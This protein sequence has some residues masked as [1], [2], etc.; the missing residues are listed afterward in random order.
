MKRLLL[1]CVLFFAASAVVAAGCNQQSARAIAHAYVLASPLGDGNELANYVRAN[2]ALFTHGGAAIRCAS[3]LGPR[4]VRGGINAY[5]PKAYERAMG[6][7][8]SQFAPQVADSINSGAVDLYMMGAEL[9][10]LAQVLP[11][12]AN[13]NYQPFLTTG[14]YMRQQMRQILPIMQMMLAMDPGAAQILNSVNA[15]FAPIAEEQIFML[16]MMAGR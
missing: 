8:P 16:A 9:Q 11:A 7:G 5:D 2:H 14:T 3:V 4:L 15:Q 10:W 1:V 13:G 6:V 12:M